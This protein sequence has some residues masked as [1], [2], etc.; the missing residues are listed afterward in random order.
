MFKKALEGLVKDKEKQIKSVKFD[1]EVITK[2]GKKQL[3]NDDDEELL[4]E[5][6]I[7]S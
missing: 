2:E 3:E 5:Q 6:K 4:S 7:P 1:E